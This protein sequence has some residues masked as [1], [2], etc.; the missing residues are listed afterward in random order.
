MRLGEIKIEALKMMFLNYEENLTIDNLNNYLK[1]D[2]YSSY[3]VNMPGSINRCIAY[4]EQKRV[5]PSKVIE[6][7]DI[8]NSNNYFKFD[9]STI[10]DFSSI[11]RVIF[12]SNNGSYGGNIDYILEGRTLLL[13]PI[14]DGEIYRLLYKPK[15]ARVTNVSENSLELGIPDEIACLIPYFIKSELFRDDEPAEAGEARNW[16]EQNLMELYQEPANKISSVQ[17]VYSQRW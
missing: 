16:F 3:L 7:T 6:L 4:L 1:N 11:D 10:S 8:G 5:L 9:L 2:N 12:E 15:I 13:K 14:A 17:T